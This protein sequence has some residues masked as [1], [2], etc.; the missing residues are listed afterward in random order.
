MRTILQ[1]AP[2]FEYDVL[3]CSPIEM[4]ISF[5]PISVRWGGIRTRQASS[6]S[7]D[8]FFSWCAEPMHGEVGKIDS[9]GRVMARTESIGTLE[10][11][12]PSKIRTDR[13]HR[14]KARIVCIT[15]R[16]EECATELGI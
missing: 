8:D 15:Q 9:L 6:K 11:M 7:G 2:L 16:G 3:F 5:D 1:R 4:R 14:T 12:A 13:P 10:A